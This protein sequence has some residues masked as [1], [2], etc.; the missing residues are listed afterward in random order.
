MSKQTAKLT[1]EWHAFSTGLAADP[2]QLSIGQRWNLLSKT[3]ALGF[4]P[5]EFAVLSEIVNSIRQIGPC[6]S[7]SIRSNRDVIISCPCDN[8]FGFAKVGFSVMGGN[9][10]VSDGSSVDVPTLIDF[11]KRVFLEG[12]GYGCKLTP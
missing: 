11:A 12:E 10:A 2:I 9:V 1:G 8:A 7:V 6:A 4:D 3:V 5:P